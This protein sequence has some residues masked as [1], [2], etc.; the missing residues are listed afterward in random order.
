VPAQVARPPVD[1]LVTGATELAPADAELIK[2]TRNRSDLV[3][4]GV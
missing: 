3:V 1:A 4:V 2:T